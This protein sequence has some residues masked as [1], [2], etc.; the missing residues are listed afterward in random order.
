LRSCRVH[1]RKGIR[2]CGR[3]N[4]S[5]RHCDAMPLRRDLI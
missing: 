2:C 1:D 5:K 4:G 3:I